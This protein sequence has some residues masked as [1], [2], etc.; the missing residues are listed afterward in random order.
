MPLTKDALDSGKLDSLFP[1]RDGRLIVTRGR[2]GEKSLEKL[3]GVNSLPILMSKS[4]VAYLFMVYAHSG[5]YGLVHR[6]AVAT[7]ARSRRFVWIVKGR[8]L[9]RKVCNSCPTCNRMRKELLVQQMADL[10]EE[11]T[12]VSTLAAHS[13]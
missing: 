13:P 5:E 9:A 11:S 2:I 4:R 1:V 10:K 3:L 12:S 8:N 6:S 7:L